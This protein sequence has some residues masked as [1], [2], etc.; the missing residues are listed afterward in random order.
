[1]DT[2]GGQNALTVQASEGVGY[3]GTVLTAQSS[4]LGSGHFFIKVNC[5]TL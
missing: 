1:M 5:C 3:S 4:A 2:G